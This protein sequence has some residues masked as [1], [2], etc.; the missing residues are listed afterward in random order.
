MHTTQL[1]RNLIL[2]PITVQSKDKASFVIL[3]SK[4]HSGLSR[5][6]FQLSTLNFTF[7]LHFYEA[8]YDT[9]MAPRS[10]GQWQ[11]SRPWGQKKKEG[12]LTCH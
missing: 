2:A 11:K 12:W 1:Y 9:K 10:Q 4:L 8:K 3:Q 6:T 5:I 7:L